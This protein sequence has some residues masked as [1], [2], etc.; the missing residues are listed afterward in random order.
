MTPFGKNI[1]FKPIK[2]DSALLTQAD[3]LLDMGEVIAIG[4]QCSGKIDIGDKIV[5]TEYGPKQIT[6][7]DET[8]YFI[9][10]NDLFILAVQK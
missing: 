5:Y 9:E 6:I 7:K 8:Y 4:D 2:E 3:R 10:E 1:L